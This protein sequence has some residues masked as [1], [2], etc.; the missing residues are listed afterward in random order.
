MLQLKSPLKKWSYLEDR[1]GR[2]PRP[3][4]WL[5]AEEAERRSN[6][7]EA[8]ETGQDTHN[9]DDE[10]RD[11]PGSQNEPVD[12]PSDC[13]KTEAGR[14]KPEP[15]VVDTRH[16]TPYLQGVEVEA[17]DSKQLEEGANELKA[18][19][20]GSQCASDKVEE[21]DDLPMSSDALKT[22]GDL[23]FTSSE[24]AE[25]R[26]GHTK[27]EDKVVDTRHMV[28][29]LPMFEVGSIGQAWYGKHAK[30]LQASDKGSWH[31]SDEVE[32]SRDLPKSSSEV[33]K[34]VGNPT[35]QAG[36]RSME[37]AL[38][39][40]I[41]DSQHAQ[42]NSETI[43]NVPDP[44]GTPTKLPTPQVEHSRLWNSPSAQAHSATSMETDLSYMRRSSK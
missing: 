20:E 25:T 15:K 40:S 7:N 6:S 44:P 16:L 28:D 31:A 2:I 11:L 22:P 35:G 26:T 14:A 17:I 30:E 1:F 18:P 21:D 27:P 38:Q 34:P 33:L 9:S 42:T 8:A 23:P 29:V 12:S 24:H 39:M 32:E 3:E 37:D 36:E 4:I 19:D 41:E 43:A 5:V 13:A 10:S